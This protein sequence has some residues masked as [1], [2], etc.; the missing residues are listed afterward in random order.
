[1]IISKEIISLRKKISKIFYEEDGPIE[2]LMIGIE[3]CPCS[4]MWYVTPIF[5]CPG[6]G[7][8][9]Y[10]TSANVALQGVDKTLPLAI[11]SLKK[12]VKSLKKAG[13]NIYKF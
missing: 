9:S 1:M 3:Y 2:Y 5:E 6:D 12:E 7:H 11:R 4:E 13:D 8:A 10:M